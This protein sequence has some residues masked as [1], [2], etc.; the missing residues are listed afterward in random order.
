MKD[1]RFGVHCPGILQ[2]LQGLQSVKECRTAVWGGA[3]IL[4]L[5]SRS[6][7]SEIAIRMSLLGGAGKECR[8][9]VQVDDVLM[10]VQ[11]GRQEEV[12]MGLIGLFLEG[13]SAVRDRDQKIRPLIP[14]S[15]YDGEAKWLDY[16][17]WKSLVFPP[18]IPFATC[19]LCMNLSSPIPVYE[20]PWA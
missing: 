1:E 5:C 8:Q 7:S 14:S 17:K 3:N 4:L 11:K 10:S 12:L 19:K 15:E 20:L 9:V 6:P 2:A 13:M 16:F 18:A